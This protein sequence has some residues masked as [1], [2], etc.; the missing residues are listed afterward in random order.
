MFRVAAARANA[1]ELTYS[2]IV[3]RSARTSRLVTLRAVTGPGD[4]GRPVI[5]IMLFCFRRTWNFSSN[6]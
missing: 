3:R 5:T 1:D 2:L 4:N 6:E